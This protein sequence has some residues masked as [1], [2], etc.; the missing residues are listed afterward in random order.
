MAARV[1]WAFFRA[2]EG[3]AQEAEFGALGVCWES[4]FPSSEKARRVWF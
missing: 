1:L 3:A 2:F 4:L